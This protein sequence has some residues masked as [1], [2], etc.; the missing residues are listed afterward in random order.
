MHARTLLLGTLLVVS[1]LA[2]AQAPTLPKIVVEATAEKEPGVIPASN[3]AS[4]KT[5]IALIETPQAISVVTAETIGERGITRLADALRGVAGVS[6]SSTY[7]YF[8]A[9]TIRGY[10]AAY[11]SL[12][13][14]GLTTSSTNGTTNELAGLERVEVIKGAASA[15]Y[16]AT[17]LGGIVNLVSKRPRAGN[18]VDASLASGS[19][20][21]IEATVDA[22]AAL[23]ASQ[24][25]LGRVTLLYRDSDDFVDF[26]GDNRIFVAPALTWN[27]GDDTSLTILGRYQRDR[28]NPWSPLI[29]YGTVLPS[30]NGDLPIDFSVNRTGA[31]RS[32]QHQDRGQ[33][34]YAFDHAFSDSLKFSQNLRYSHT[35]IFWNNW[36]FSDD[37]LDSDIVDGVQQGHLLGLNVYGPY[38]QVD[39]DWTVDSRMY[40]ELSAGTISHKFMAGVDFKRNA[41]RSADQGGNFDTS[42]NTLDILDPNYEATLIHDP[43]WA[44]ADSL[45]SRGVG[46]YLQ[47]HIGFAERL[48]VTLGGRWDRVNI[49]GIREHAFSPNV[50]VN[51]LITPDV[52][53]YVNAAR[54]FTP[55][56]GWV[57]DVAGNTLPPESGRNFEVGVKFGNSD[58]AFNAQV[59]AFQLTRRN[60]ATEDPANPFFY[61]ITG[62]QRSR[63]LE[64]EG[65][66][67]AS[68]SWNLNWAYTFIDAVITSDNIFPTGVQLSNIPKHNVYL[69]TSYEVPQGPLASLSLGLGALYNSRKNSALAN[70]DF[71]GDGVDDP[72]IPLPSYTLLDAVV[73][74]PFKEWQ[75]QLSVGN[76]LDKRYYPDAGYFTRV[77]PG[78]PRNVRVSI[79][80]R[81]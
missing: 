56:F 25:L 2:S 49:D 13:L 74:Y 21:L 29:A 78:E 18:F 75:A 48:F 37:I 12:F 8:D 15:L 23:N 67:A 53:L 50:G 1:P 65:G 32:V 46:Y 66:W 51:Y 70:F 63:G 40:Y 5:D 20:N 72:A 24:S 41:S 80:K 79:S 3:S 58:Q 38:R 69:F 55:Q 14:D 19:Y 22:N 42:V 43:V 64:F 33:I 6:R 47:D 17:P 30:V 59:A 16:G 54:S 10:D 28:D 36:L 71:D 44:Y 34:G 27:I 52:G 68:E 31:D 62:E 45:K 61:V 39:N 11:N 7:G 73:S 81:F 77:T 57:T 60:V 26:S 35:D 76:L 9:Y 4:S